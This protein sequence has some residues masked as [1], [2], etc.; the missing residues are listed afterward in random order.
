MPGASSG[1]PMNSMPAASMAIR[2]LFSDLALEEGTPVDV[3]I[4]T[5]VRRTNPASL[6]SCSADQPK[7]ARPARICSTVINVE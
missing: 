6:A 2:M 7:A 3:S 4:L 1:E 5:I